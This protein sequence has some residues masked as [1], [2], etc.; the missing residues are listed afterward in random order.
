MVCTFCPPT[1]LGDFYRIPEKSPKSSA[2]KMHRACESKDQILKKMRTLHSAVKK[3]KEKRTR[4]KWSVYLGP[5]HSPVPVVKKSPVQMFCRRFSMGSVEMGLDGIVPFLA[6]FFVSLR[7]F[8]F[9]VFFVLL[10]SFS[11]LFSLQEAKTAI[12]SFQSFVREENLSSWCR[13]R[14]ACKN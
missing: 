1:I 9:V 10:H 14:T 5:T 12:G 7:F 3:R 2:D 6:L 13:V 4:N 8:V 11:S